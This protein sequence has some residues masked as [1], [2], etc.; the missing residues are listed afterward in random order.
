MTKYSTRTWFQSLF[1]DC[2]GLEGLILWRLVSKSRMQFAEFVLFCIKLLWLQKM[3]WHTVV[4]HSLLQWCL[5]VNETFSCTKVVLCTGIEGFW[6]NELCDHVTWRI[7]PSLENLFHWILGLCLFLQSQK[8]QNPGGT[9][10]LGWGGG[11][12][13]VA[14]ANFQQY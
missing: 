12:Q 13:V 6:L 5:W 1:C 2:C 9:E 10:Y 4:L 7:G 14:K 3:Q 8:S 11:I